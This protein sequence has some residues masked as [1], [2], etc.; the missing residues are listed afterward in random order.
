[1][2]VARISFR[3]FDVWMLYRY[4]YVYE[5]RVLFLVYVC[6]EKPSKDRLNYTLFNQ[7]YAH[8][9][10]RDTNVEYVM[11]IAGSTRRLRA[12]VP[13]LGVC[14]RTRFFLFFFS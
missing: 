2:D 10:V 5:R 8:D 11:M 1:M 4:L 12:Y 7:M 3:L 6:I 9:R 14:V 13:V